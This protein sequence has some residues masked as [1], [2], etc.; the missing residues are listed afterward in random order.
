MRAAIVILLTAIASLLSVI[1]LLILFLLLK[2]S[3]SSPARTPAPSHVPIVIDSPFFF[4]EIDNPSLRTFP[5]PAPDP[6]EQRRLRTV[7]VP[8]PEERR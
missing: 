8:D 3:V 4:P 7:P 5:M 2:S 1:A 6:Q